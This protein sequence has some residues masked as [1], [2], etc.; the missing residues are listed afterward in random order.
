MRNEN[1]LVDQTIAK[2]T[3]LPTQLRFITDLKAVFAYR[4]AQYKKLA[5]NVPHLQVQLPVLPTS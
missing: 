2:T 3:K 5:R 4:A 1:T